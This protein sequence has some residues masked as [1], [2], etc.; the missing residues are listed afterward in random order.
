MRNL[1]RTKKARTILIVVLAAI[2]L[3][4]IIGIIVST[5]NPKGE[6]GIVSIKYEDTTENTN[7]VTGVTEEGFVVSAQ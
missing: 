7:Y 5:G 4:F 3:L 2:S 1:F 6:K